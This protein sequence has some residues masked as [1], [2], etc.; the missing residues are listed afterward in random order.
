MSMWAGIFEVL[1]GKQ[2]VGCSDPQAPVAESLPNCLTAIL[3]CPLAPS[4]SL[5]T[6]SVAYEEE[7]AAMD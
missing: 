5:E 7:S 4:L 1:L 2:K 6:D 3:F